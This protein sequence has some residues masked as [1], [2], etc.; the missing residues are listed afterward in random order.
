MRQVKEKRKFDRWEL[1]DKAHIDFEGKQ[2]HIKILDVSIGG[3][4]I[5]TDFPLEKEKVFNGT[6][7]ILPQ[8]RPFF[9]RGKVVWTVKK[10]NAFESGVIFDKVSTIPLA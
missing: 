8:S 9:I 5:T 2:E 10:D 1:E 3:M 4:R 6:F 7:N